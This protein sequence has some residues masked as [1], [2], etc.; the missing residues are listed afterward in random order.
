MPNENGIL[1]IFYLCLS[2]I[3]TSIIIIPFQTYNPL[4][5]KN[6]K[7]LE[8]IKESSD[9]EIIDTISKN[10]I[11]ADLEIGD[12]KSK[13]STF[14]E[15]AIDK[16]YFKDL[17]IH[18]GLPPLNP[19]ENSNYTYAYHNNKLLKDIFKYNYYNSSLSKSYKYIYSCPEYL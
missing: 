11:Y 19:I 5:T 2:P 4:L 8:I 17:S 12:N 1:F 10:L 18:T 14:F 15:M 3:I 13:I 16:I 6:N 7:I 9:I